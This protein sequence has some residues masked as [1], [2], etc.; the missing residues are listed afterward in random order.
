M[1][2]YLTDKDW[3]PRFDS[4]FFTCKIISRTLRETPPNDG[5]TIGTKG[6]HPAVYYH[7]KVNMGKKELIVKRRFSQF[8]MLYDELKK[9]PPAEVSPEQKQQFNHV[10]LPPKA[11]FFQ[12][13]DDEFLDNRQE[14]LTIFVHNILKIQ[15]Y[16]KHPAVEKFLRLDYMRDSSMADAS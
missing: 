6:N 7:I 14:E 13:I 16:S 11:C 5:Y 15:N 10:H 2:V 12:K 9:S 1:A 3:S 4:A 8:R